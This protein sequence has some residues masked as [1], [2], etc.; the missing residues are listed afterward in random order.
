M[1]TEGFRQEYIRRF[2]LEPAS[3]AIQPMTIDVKRFSPVRSYRDMRD[4]FAVPRDAPLI[5]IV[6]RF[7]KYRRMGTFLRA[8]KRLL[9]EVP[10][11]RFLVIGRS[12]QIQ[13]TVVKPV[14][15][16]GLSHRVI[17][18][19]Y[20]RHDYIDTLACLDIFSLLM[21]GS[22]GT[23]RAVREAMAMG[24]PC[25]VSDYGMLPEIV[26]HGKSGRVVPDSPE[27]LALAWSGLIRDPERL[28]QM[29]RAARQHA[30]EQ[31]RIETVGP[32]LEAFYER[33]VRSKKEKPAT[34]P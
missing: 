26:E 5:G 6:G 22:D 21:P 17:L 9:Q 30:L 4:E 16:M 31:F 28:E 27:K 13:E 15:Q 12:S 2:A 23:A 18:A 8:A 7:Q 25:V 19:G 20:R 29:G 24:K 10:D 11:A 3:T 34:G 32:V 14:R 33:I 1:F